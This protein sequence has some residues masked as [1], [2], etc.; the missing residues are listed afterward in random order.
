M[1]FFRAIADAAK[2]ANDEAHG[3]RLLREV[4]STFSCLE[5]LDGMVSYV[6]AR[7]YLQ[8]QERLIGQMLNWSREGRIEI[9]RTMQRQARDAFDTDMAGGY[10]KWLAGAWLESKERNSLKAQQAH[11]LLGGLAENIRKELE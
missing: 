3:E 5:N 10:A 6:A 7:G 1:G 2:E 8:I 9:G 11:A 4:Q